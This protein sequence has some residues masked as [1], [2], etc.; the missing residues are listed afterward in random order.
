MKQTAHNQAASDGA[1]REIPILPSVYGLYMLR[2]LQKKGIRTEAVLEGSNLERGF[3]EQPDQYLS[4]RQLEPLL[5]RV[6]ELAP[7]PST[8][9]EFGQELGPISH[10][11]VGFTLFRRMSFREM[12]RC[13][14]EYLRVRLPLMEIRIQ[15]SEAGLTL[16]IEDL[17][18]LD[19]LREF[20]TQ[21]YM[22]SICSLTHMI[23]RNTSLRFSFPPPENPAVYE[24]LAGC[25]VEFSGQANQAFVSFSSTE[26]DPVRVSTDVLTSGNTDTDI[27]LEDDREVVVQVRH[28]LLKHPGRDGTLEK[29]AHRLD[30]SPRSLRR[31][32]ANA[33]FSFSEL[34]NEVRREFATRYLTGTSMPLE[35][36]AT[37]LGYSDQASFSKAFR[38]W[39]G[40]NPGTVRREA[41]ER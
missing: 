7:T 20:V 1:A 32:L 4:M 26:P 5:T 27:D 18:H 40:R 17:W 11:L 30:L 38:G 14:V 29:M 6:M 28:L 23:T 10:G 34:R 41:R 13:S 39:T 31:K 36:I 3:F 37:R 35:K 25:R 22:G 9:F 2:F 33:G 19:G 12:M 24:R 16:M 8:A 21:I 15:D